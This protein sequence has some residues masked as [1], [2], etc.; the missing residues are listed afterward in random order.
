M[1]RNEVEEI[2]RLH[3]QLFKDD[4]TILDESYGNN[5]GTSRAVRYIVRDF[6]EK[7]KDEILKGLEL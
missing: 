7:N 3:I 6:I 1:P 5:I 2:I 4:K